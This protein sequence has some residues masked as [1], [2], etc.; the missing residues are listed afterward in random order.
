MRFAICSLQL[1]LERG[2]LPVRETDPLAID[3]RQAAAVLRG[4]L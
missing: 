3:R 4:N 1:S 2:I